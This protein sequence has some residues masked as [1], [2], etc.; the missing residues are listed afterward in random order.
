VSGAHPDSADSRVPA[1]RSRPNA[2]AP[3]VVGGAPAADDAR[4]RCRGLHRLPSARW[5]DR[6]DAAGILI[7]RGWGKAPQAVDLSVNRPSNP[8]EDMTADDL[9]ALIALGRQVQAAQREAEEA[10]MR[11]LPKRSSSSAPA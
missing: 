5:A 8:F 9:S 11:E 3:S 6:I 10:A 2:S 1:A 7:D 4:E